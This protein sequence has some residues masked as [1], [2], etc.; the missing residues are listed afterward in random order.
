MLST[1][2]LEEDTHIRSLWFVLRNTKYQFSFE[3]NDNRPV[4]STLSS[5]ID[6][7]F[8]FPPKKALRDLLKLTQKHEERPNHLDNQPHTPP[9]KCIPKRSS[10]SHSPSS[11]RRPSPNPQLNNPTSLQSPPPAP[12]PPQ[13]PQPQAVQPQPVS[14][15][16]SP[17]C[18]PAQSPASTAPPK[19]S[20][21]P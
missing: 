9:P 20:N 14:Q 13:P 15:A 16:S 7:S 19:Q 11:P 10:P 2:H 17:N 8:R 6:R 5:I 21:A 4:L 12:A 18:P 3:F 1:F